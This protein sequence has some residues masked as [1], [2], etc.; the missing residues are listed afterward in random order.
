G[1][2]VDN[3]GVDGLEPAVSGLP[4]ESS[5]WSRARFRHL[6]ALYGAPWAKP[7]GKRLAAQSVSL[8]SRYEQFRMSALDCALM[9][10]QLSKLDQI[11]ASRIR[12]ATQIVQRVGLDNP[13][14]HF[15]RPEN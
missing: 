8:S 3:I 13:V 6:L 15:Q 11:I 5:D 14:F 1:A 7:F 2:I 9:Q 12:N 4:V 10:F